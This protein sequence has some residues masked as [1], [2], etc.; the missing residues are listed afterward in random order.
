MDNYFFEPETT[1]KEEFLQA[2]LEATQNDGE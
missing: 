2:L 1:T